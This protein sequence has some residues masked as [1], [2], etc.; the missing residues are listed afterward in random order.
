MKF[1]L[2][3]IVTKVTPLQACT[4]DTA[5]QCCLNTVLI[6][7]TLKLNVN[8]FESISALYLE[9]R[10]ILQLAWQSSWKDYQA[11]KQTMWNAIISSSALACGVIMLT[12][13]TTHFWSALFSQQTKT[14]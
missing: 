2:L 3:Q 1:A 8:A 12:S 7:Y 9:F 5:R 10:A 4:L 6:L 13:M 14:H 11:L